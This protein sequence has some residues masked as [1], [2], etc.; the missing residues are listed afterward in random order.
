[1]MFYPRL[2]VAE[3]SWSQ[4]DLGMPTYLLLQ[5]IDLIGLDFCDFRIIVDQ[6]DTTGNGLFRVWGFHLLVNC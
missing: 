6:S 4:Y 3:T 2:G 5:L 1:M